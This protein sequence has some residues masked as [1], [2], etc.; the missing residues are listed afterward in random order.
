M[1]ITKISF[2]PPDLIEVRT[3]TGLTGYGSGA[4]CQQSLRRRPEVAVGRSPFEAEA[5]F[6]E[7]TAMGATPGGLDLALWDLMGQSLR[8][9]AREILGKS[10]RDKIL[11]CPSVPSVD[12]AR[13][14]SIIRVESPGELRRSGT[15]IGL[16]FTARDTE[17]ALRLGER[18]QDAC[19]EFWESPIPGDNPEGYS[20]LRD[21]LRI[22][23]A[24]GPGIPLDSLI[25]NYIQTGLVDLVIQDVSVC[26]LTGLRRLFYYCWLFHVRLAPY[27]SGTP[28]STAAAVHGAA[29]I[30]PASNAIAAPPVFVIS[31]GLPEVELTVPSCPGLGVRI[32]RPSCA[33]SFV[34]GEGQ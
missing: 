9:P 25:K 24:A 6:D 28:L 8:K 3:N 1:I 12:H 18:L 26:G 11:S 30:P 4:L 2:F 27:C 16:R 21:A 19:L 29:C 7:M 31:G 32:E 33:P 23:I 15:R 13:E 17:D 14:H 20:K 34:L 5:I 10:Y 22:S